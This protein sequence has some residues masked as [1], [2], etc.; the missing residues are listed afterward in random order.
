MKRGFVQQKDGD[1]PRSARRSVG[2][3]LP[4]LAIQ[5]TCQPSSEASF[6]GPSNTLPVNEQVFRG[7]SFRKHR[8]QPLHKCF[9]CRQRG[10]WAN[11]TSCPSCL[12]GTVA[13][14]K[15]TT[16]TKLHYRD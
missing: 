15:L 7:Q 8:S 11:S 1:W 12:R 4:D 13:G 10:H 14:R 9:S 2:I 5:S 16:N 3:H 6:A